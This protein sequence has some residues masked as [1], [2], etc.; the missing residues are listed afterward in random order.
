MWHGDGNLEK[1]INFLD[2]S[3]K[4]DFYDFVIK[5]T[6]FNPHNMFICKSKKILKNYYDSVFPW[7]ERC[8]KDFGFYNLKGYG[9]KRI[10]GFLAERYMSYWFQKNTKYTTIPIYFQDITSF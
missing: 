4:S 1:A 8:E 5:N 6:C 9:L 7:L 10:Y 3:E 2:E